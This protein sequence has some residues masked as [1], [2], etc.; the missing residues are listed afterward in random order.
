MSFIQKEQSFRDYWELLLAKADENWILGNSAWCEVWNEE[1]LDS[2]YSG[3]NYNGERKFSK[4]RPSRKNSSPCKLYTD[5]NQRGFILICEDE[6]RENMVYLYFAFVIKKYRNQ[7]IMKGILSQIE[8]D[9]QGKK[10]LLCVNNIGG[11]IYV[12]SE[13][14]QKVGFTYSSES[15]NRELTFVK[16]I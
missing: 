16:Q 9:Y 12:R 7:G 1:T 5:L 4:Q 2:C 8:K 14:W 6:P 15:F 3:P 11:S 10:L 13:I